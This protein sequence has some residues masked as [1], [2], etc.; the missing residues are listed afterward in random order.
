MR[1]P[2]EY[3]GQ[4]LCNTRQ[5]QPLGTRK[6]VAVDTS[7][8]HGHVGLAVR[9]GGG[10]SSEQSQYYDQNAADGTSSPAIPDHYVAQERRDQLYQW[11]SQ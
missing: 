3:D 1:P 4:I 2:D 9:G 10:G 8:A 5:V 7:L 11:Q 6:I